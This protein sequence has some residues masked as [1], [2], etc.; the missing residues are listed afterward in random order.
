[1]AKMFTQTG[2]MQPYIVN[3]LITNGLVLVLIA[4]AINFMQDSRE[5]F[6]RFEEKRFQFCR[7]GSQASHETTIGLLITN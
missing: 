6:V 1:M 7:P 3:T 2:L 4:G 5:K